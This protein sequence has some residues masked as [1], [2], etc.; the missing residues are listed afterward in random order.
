MDPYYF[1]SK[2]KIWCSM[3]EVVFMLA[4]CT[5]RNQYRWRQGASCKNNLYL[6]LILIIKLRWGLSIEMFWGW[7]NKLSELHRRVVSRLSLPDELHRVHLSFTQQSRK[8]CCQKATDKTI[9][10][11]APSVVVLEDRCQQRVIRAALFCDRN[12]WVF[13]HEVRR[14]N[15]SFE[16]AKCPWLIWEAVRRMWKPWKYFRWENI[17]LLEEMLHSQVQERMISDRDLHKDP[18]A[19]VGVRELLNCI[20]CCAEIC[21]KNLNI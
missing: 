6:Y 8:S 17:R 10:S 7:L 15:T 1:I 2:Q 12:N 21:Q 14:W 3:L 9:T 19:A 18:E 13:W 16:K 4:R 20:S 5:V 11:L